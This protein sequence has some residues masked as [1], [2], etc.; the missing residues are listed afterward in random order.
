MPIADCCF[1]YV[2]LITQVCRFFC[3]C[4][5]CFH[6]FQEL[7]VHGFCQWTIF[8]LVEE[9][10]IIFFFFPFRVIYKTMLNGISSI[11]EEFGRTHK[12]TRTKEIRILHFF[13]S[14]SFRFKSDFWLKRVVTMS[15]DI[16]FFPPSMQLLKGAL[17]SV[18]FSLKIIIKMPFIDQSAE[19]KCQWFA[20]VFSLDLNDL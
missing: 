18:F 7:C 11:L 14:S 8:R 4:T 2:S 20:G 10:I 3:C 15:R 17:I 12:K 19:V 5:F 16:C 6:F 13:F 9:H 1:P